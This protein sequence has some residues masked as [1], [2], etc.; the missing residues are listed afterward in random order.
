MKKLILIT[1]MA[2][3]ESAALAADSI[4]YEKYFEVDFAA[5]LPD[6]KAIGEEMDR[7][8]E[9]YEP[10]YIVSWDMG[11]VFDRLW[12]STITSY[13]SGETR[14]K[15][16]GE[17]DMLE[18]INSMPKEYYPYIGPYLHTL[19][20]I[21]PKILNM[22]GIKETKNTFPKQIAPQL[23]GIEDLDFLS[24]H[25]YILLMPQMWPE[26][27]QA[28]EKPVLRPAKIPQTPYEPEF[29]ARV[30]RQVPKQ[31][32][33]GAAQEYEQPN[34][35]QLRTLNITKSSLLT[36]AD[37]KA[38][39]KTIDKLKDFA[40]PQNILKTARAGAELDFWEHQT[41]TALPINS[42]KDAVNPC[43]RLVLKIKWAGLETEF[44]KTIA[45]EGFNAEE[46]AY[47]CDKTIKAHRI[48]RISAPKLAAL[49]SFK[50]GVYNAYF[51]TL[52][53]KWRDKQFAAMQSVIEMYKAP[54]AD[55]MTAL[56]N[57]AAINAALKPLGG[58]LIISPISD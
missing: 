42:L 4:S 20:G 36:S 15:R 40:T 49:K 10:R 55:V 54:R 33:G 30:L 35:D 51:N 50:R 28:D 57:E 25:L 56:K 34:R 3:I 32:F 43:Q 18:L 17:E 1:V 22:P 14:L 29:F 46:W 21:S 7:V 52:S 6:V 45:D 38:F 47:T 8:Y 53:P 39:L 31:G 19:R 9:V 26:N 2:L 41:D 44:S 11:P 37:V 27:R 16:S 13:G 48:A 12:A 24:P 23:Q 5:P 58:M